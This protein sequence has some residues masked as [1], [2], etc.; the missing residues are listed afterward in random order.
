[1]N[2][3]NLKQSFN[4][5]FKHQ[6]TPLIVGAHGIGK[7]SIV[8]QF[9]AENGYLYV[10]QPLGTKEAGDIQGLLDT[11]EGTSKFMPPVWVASLNNWAKQNPDKYAVLHLDEINHIH[12]DMQAVL[13]G[14]LLGNQIGDVKMEPNVRYVGSMNP[15][16]KDYPG[17]FDFR[18]L[19][20]VDRFCHIDLRPTVQEWASFAKSGGIDQTW[21]DFFV[22]TPQLL[23]P[24]T[25]HYD[26]FKKIKGSR[27]SAI[28]AA[29]LAADGA[30]DE[31]LEGIV[32]PAVVS[33]FAAYRKEQDEQGLKTTDILGRKSLTKKT[34]DTIQKWVDTEQ[35]GKLD[36]LCNQLKA[37]INAAA[38]NSMS[39]QDA[40]RITD[41]VLV[42]PVD[43]A[44]AFCLDVTL[45]SQS[46][47]MKFDSSVN[48][49]F[50]DF[51]K[52]QIDA[53]KVTI[54]KG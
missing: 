33:S 39:Q 18:N 41:L 11:A 54:K 8:S 15:P 31:L 3:S 40:D 2:I 21:V 22:A 17:V 27:R 45:H 53:G 26:V 7:T 29:Q 36:A 35:Y 5:L 10:M 28:K 48:K 23:D 47:N 50:F 6:V 9:C 1:M 43:M 51:W 12:K 44:Y 32:G 49:R 42:L 30:S 52:G 24:P 34:K 38:P 20:L 13:F 19:A 4:L 16:T 46:I 25:E 14:A 37:E